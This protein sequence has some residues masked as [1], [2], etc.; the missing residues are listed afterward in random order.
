MS[1]EARPLSDA[2]MEA[3]SGGATSDSMD[4]LGEEQSLRMQTVMDRQSKAA[5]TLSNLLKKS[6]DTTSSIVNNLK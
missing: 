2:E 4:D 3:V 1:E 6:S 5:S